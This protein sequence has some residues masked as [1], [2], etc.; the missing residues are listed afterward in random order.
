MKARRTPACC[1]EP[2]VQRL[3]RTGHPVYAGQDR[4]QN[5]IGDSPADRALREPLR[6]GLSVRKHAVLRRRDPRELN[7]GPFWLPIGTL[8]GPEGSQDHRALFDATAHTVLL[9][10]PPH[11]LRDGCGGKRLE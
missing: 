11:Q 2:L 10:E 4:H 6:N 9:V 5:P 3:G 1:R 8:F 7:I